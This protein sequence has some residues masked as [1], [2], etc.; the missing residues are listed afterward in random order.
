MIKYITNFSFFLILILPFILITGPAIP[1]ISIT[2]TGLFFLFML[3]FRNEF[4]EIYKHKW[5]LI[6]IIFWIF[7]LFISLFSENKYLAYKDAIIFIRILFIP[8][9]IYFWILNDEYK[10]KLLTLVVCYAV[11]FVCLDLSHISFV[12]LFFSLIINRL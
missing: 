6:S 9:F 1:D 5:V 4:T 7:I 12:F 11:V 10:I 2:I 8:I 3:L